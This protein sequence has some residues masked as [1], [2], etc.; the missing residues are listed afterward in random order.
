MHISFS[1]E[2]QCL[3]FSATVPL[4]SVLFIPKAERAGVPKYCLDQ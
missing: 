2:P 1:G 4:R 3:R